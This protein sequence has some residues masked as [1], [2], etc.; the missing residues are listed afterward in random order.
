M[1]VCVCSP[2]LRDLDGFIKEV[3]DGLTKTVEEG[4]YQGL[5]GVM[6]HLM[7]MKDRQAATDTMFSPLKETIQFLKDFGEELPDEVHAQL[8]V[9]DTQI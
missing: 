9:G 6:G 5:V 4:D 7:R 2:S 8:Q 1:F 3:K